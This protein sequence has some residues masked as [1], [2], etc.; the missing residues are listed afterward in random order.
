MQGAADLAHDRLTVEALRLA[1]D[2]WFLRR[3]I[4]VGSKDDP[5]RTLCTHP[6]RDGFNCVGPFMEDLP[7]SC[8]LWEPG[9]PPRRTPQA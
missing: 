7:T 9:P 5:L 2:C 1:A 4:E 6:I 3:T 8:G